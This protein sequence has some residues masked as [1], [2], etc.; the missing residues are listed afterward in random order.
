MRRYSEKEVRSILRRAASGPRS[1]S[2]SEGVT[3]AELERVAE[4]MGIPPERIREAAGELD[5]RP[6][7]SGPFLFGVPTRFREQRAIGMGLTP[8][9]WEQ[10]ARRLNAGYGHHGKTTQLGSMLEWRC[11]EDAG[12]TVVS[13]V[14]REGE[15]NVRAETDVTTPKLMA[16]FLGVIAPATILLGVAV[17]R[18]SHLGVHA[19]VNLATALACVAVPY[20][21]MSGVMAWW[22]RDRSERQRRALDEIAELVPVAASAQV[23]RPASDFRPQGE[24]PEDPVDLHA[25]S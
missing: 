21:I 10:I 23:R 9:L 18:V 11:K 15:T 17:P 3:L 7:R 22:H 14:V 5:R 2:S 25:E 4:E 13:V 6:E 8:E 1:S 19:W 16:L 20:A 12:E 24:S